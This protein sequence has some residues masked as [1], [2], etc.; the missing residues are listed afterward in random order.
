MTTILLLTMVLSAEPAE[1]QSVLLKTFRS[2]FINIQPGQGKF[3]HSFTMGRAVG[4]HASERPA[5]TVKL[6]YS[7]WIAKYEIPQNLWTAVMGSNPSRWKGKRN[8]VEMITFDEAQEFCKK[9]TGMMR[10]LGLIESNEMVRLPSEAEWEYVARAGTT[11]LYSFGND[12]QQLDEFAWHTGNASGNDPPVGAKKPNPWGLYD[13]HGYL[14]EWCADVAHESY[15]G[16][17]ADGSAWTAD[18]DSEQRVIRSGSWKDEAEMLTSSRRSGAFRGV[19][20]TVSFTGGVAKH[21][22]DDAVGFRCVLAEE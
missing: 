11:S 14:W 7:F 2:E 22:R 18:G 9:A 21:L 20:G 3:P 4:G 16:A 12:L 6:D 17:P 10:E 5:H 1:D 15:Q 8:S 13:I 19:Q